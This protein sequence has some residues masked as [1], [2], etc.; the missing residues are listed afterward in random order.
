MKR[1]LSQVVEQQRGF[2]LRGS[3]HGHGDELSLIPP[4]PSHHVAHTPSPFVPSSTAWGSPPVHSAPPTSTYA[5]T[6]AQASGPP[7]A[8]PGMHP[9]HAEGHGFVV[10]PSTSS[11]RS[12]VSG[13]SPRVPKRPR[14]LP[15]PS[16]S[17][18]DDFSLGFGG[19]SH[20]VS[21][22]YLDRIG[23]RN[24]PVPSHSSGHPGG[25]GY[26]QTRLR[27]G[28]DS[29]MPSTSLDHNHN[30]LTMLGSSPHSGGRGPE[31]GNR[32]PHMG[33]G[34]DWPI[35]CKFYFLSVSN[36]LGSCPRRQRA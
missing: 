19:T 4:S 30:F 7:Y 20:G 36:P 8:G 24:H 35:A 2:S 21:N 26:P 25:T 10:Q 22:S 28:S 13:G 14:I 18:T 11:D 3:G 1:P 34:M 9:Q 15:A 6:G 17:P 16:H 29:S 33:G 27:G 23:S 32:G 5:H 31:S 12:S